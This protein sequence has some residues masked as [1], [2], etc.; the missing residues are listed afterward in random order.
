MEGGKE[1]GGDEVNV[2]EGSGVRNRN[3]ALTAY[4]NYALLAETR[5]CAAELDLSVSQYVGHAVKSYN[6]AVQ[7]RLARKAQGN[8]NG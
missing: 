1:N 3:L 4:I 7:K 6:A 5:K 2:G 8:Q